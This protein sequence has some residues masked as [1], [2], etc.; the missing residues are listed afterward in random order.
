MLCKVF[1]GKKFPSFSMAE[2]SGALDR[3]TCAACG[4]SVAQTDLSIEE[5]TSP[6]DLRRPKVCVALIRRLN[7]RTADRKISQNVVDLLF[8]EITAIG[9][10]LL[11]ELRKQCGCDR[12]A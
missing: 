6:L 7:V 9:H 11:F 2:R 5:L 10:A 12:I 4:C 3:V 8:G 1:L